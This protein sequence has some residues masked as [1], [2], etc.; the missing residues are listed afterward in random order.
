ME[1][2]MKFISENILLVILIIVCGSI[3]FDPG[4]GYT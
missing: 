2:I 3:W 1:M 4:D